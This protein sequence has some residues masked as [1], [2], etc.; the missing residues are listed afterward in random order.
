MRNHLE[1][2][3]GE[4]DA[5]KQQRADNW[6]EINRLKELNDMRGKEQIEKVEAMKALDY[7]LSRT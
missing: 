6:R 4:L 7:D 1:G 3:E 5:L 2:L